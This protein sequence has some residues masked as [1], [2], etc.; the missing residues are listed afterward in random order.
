ME[1]LSR[2]SDRDLTGLMAGKAPTDGSD[3]EDLA[4]FVSATKAAFQE[5]P[6]AH[7]AARHLD[8]IVET[9]QRLAADGGSEPRRARRRFAPSNPF[10]SLAARL[11][12]TAALLLTGF[13]GAAYAGV[14]PDP[15]QRAVADAAG[16]LG[17]SLPEPDD[18]SAIDTHD[19][20]PRDRSDATRE[21]RGRGAQGNHTRSGRKDPA[22]NDSDKR[23]RKRGNDQQNGR[24]QGAGGAGTKQQSG[25]DQG[26]SNS[27]DDQ[28]NAG[29]Q[30]ATDQPDAGTQNATGQPNGGDQP[31]DGTQGATGRPNGGTQGAT[32]PQSDDQ[33]TSSPAGLEE[34]PATSRADD[35]PG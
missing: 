20:T 15:V 22:R 2:L 6:D 11:A 30:A 27:R 23:T 7:T 5:P 32:D 10:E 31:N 28:P 19:G 1:R 17:V 14:L 16:S 21:D 26:A 3:L 9:S 34:S 25:G 12:A 24:N 8:A 18:G 4:A 13:S 35:A 33:G 29:N